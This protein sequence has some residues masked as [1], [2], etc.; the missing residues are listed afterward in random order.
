MVTVDVHLA[1]GGMG[2]QLLRRPQWAGMSAEQAPGRQRQR[3]KQGE[4]QK[5]LHGHLAQR[6]A[7]DGLME[8]CH[9]VGDTS[10]QKAA[11]HY[12]QARRRDRALPTHPSFR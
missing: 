3:G 1:L 4:A 8:L 5:G 6:E 12:G 7:A 2:H 9:R 11:D 10:K